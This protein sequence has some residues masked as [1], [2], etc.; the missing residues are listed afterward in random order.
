[1]R[2]TNVKKIYS[3]HC[4]K[5]YDETEE[6]LFVEEIIGILLWLINLALSK[7]LSVYITGPSYW[8]SG[9]LLNGKPDAGVQ[10]HIWAI[11]LYKLLIK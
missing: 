3:I 5:G 9:I 4:W 8:T 10:T 6:Y 2:L 11:L 1:M 7:V